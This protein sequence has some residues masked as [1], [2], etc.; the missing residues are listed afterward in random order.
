M[1]VAANDVRMDPK[2]LERVEDLFN[3]QIETG[4]H[5]GAALGVYRYGKP[6]L[7]LH[8]GVADLETG[9]PVTEKA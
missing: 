4:H 5:P 8:G 1:V 9:S 6:V 2:G 7:D 3:Q